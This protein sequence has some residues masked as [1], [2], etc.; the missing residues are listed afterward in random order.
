MRSL[1]TLSA[2]QTSIAAE[3]LVH[4]TMHVGPAK[5]VV[6]AFRQ[7]PPNAAQLES[8]INLVEDAI[9]ATGLHAIPRGT[10]VAD[11]DALHE[12]LGVVN[13]PAQLSLAQ[14]EQR[15]QDI[16]MPAQRFPSTPVLDL[17]P[18]LLA[19]LILVRECMHHLGFAE[20]VLV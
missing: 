14:V 2:G 13:A 8:A 5:I 10:L 1:L 7:G 16:A 9:M 4:V 6:Q 19:T 18:Q 15:Y 12:A 11:V 20:L 3:G 17:A